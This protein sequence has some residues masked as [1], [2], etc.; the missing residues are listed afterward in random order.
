MSKYDCPRHLIWVPYV[1]AHVY[2]LTKSTAR[3][4]TDHHHRQET[5]LVSKG[6]IIWNTYMHL[7]LLWWSLHT[8]RSIINFLIWPALHWIL[9]G[10]M[11]LY[12][13]TLIKG[14]CTCSIPVR[15]MMLWILRGER[16]R[17]TQTRRNDGCPL[18]GIDTWHEHKSDTY[19]NHSRNDSCP[20][21]GID[22]CQVC[23]L[24]TT[25]GSRRNGCPSMN[26]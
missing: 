13:C 6:I 25:S 22:T 7:H 26:H 5:V 14:G 15:R 20:L 10:I 3:Y 24:C 9:A 17:S 8:L 16:G 12:T 4:L 23:L 1:T 21:E 11:L 18:E 2:Y 19:Q